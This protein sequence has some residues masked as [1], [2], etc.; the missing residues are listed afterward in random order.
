MKALQLFAMTLIMVSFSVAANADERKYKCS[1]EAE[2]GGEIQVA[3][4]TFT[5]G[6]SNKISKANSSINVW[7]RTITKEFRGPINPPKAGATALNIKSIYLNGAEN[8]RINPFANVDYLIFD[9]LLEKLH[10]D[11][12]PSTLTLSFFSTTGPVGNRGSETFKLN[13]ETL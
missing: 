9:G 6:F 4:V 3:E 7:G 11:E 13:C 5:K 1:G 12:L 2:G 10:Y 8:S